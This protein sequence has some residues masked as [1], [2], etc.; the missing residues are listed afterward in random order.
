MA[1]ESTNSG[2]VRLLALAGSMREASVNRKLLAVAVQSAEAHGASVDG[3]DLRELALPLYDGDLEATQGVPEPVVR[4][5]ARIAAADGLLI[6]SPEYNNS[7][8]GVLK[9][10]IDWA[11]RGPDK[12][13]P[14]KC[15]AL[16]GASPGMYGAVRALPHLQQVMAALGVWVVPG[17]VTLPGAGGAFDDSGALTNETTQQ[18]L[19]GA[20]TR[21]IEHLSAAGNNG[22]E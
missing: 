12:V 13:F 3:A 21:L 14:G 2:K 19:D 7:I 11:S 17:L 8:P 9:N 4:F 16:F 18:A 1:R 15:A 5:K 6:A 22:A 20:V 10:A